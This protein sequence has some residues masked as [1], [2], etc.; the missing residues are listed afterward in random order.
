VRTRRLQASH[1][2]LQTIKD[3]LISRDAWIFARFLGA[4][5]LVYRAL[6]C[7]VTRYEPL[8]RRRLL[9]R[10]RQ[11]CRLRRGPSKLG[12]AMAAF[13]AVASC[14]GLRA[15][16]SAF[17]AAQG[18]TIYLDAPERRQTIALY[19]VIRSVL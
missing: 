14:A 4:M 9:T 2:P 10:R 5:G 3:A 15:A 16:L 7:L 6:Q 13:L 19:L 17:A 8:A 12:S 18:S 1:R 11:F